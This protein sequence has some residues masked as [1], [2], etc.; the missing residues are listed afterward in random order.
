MEAVTPGHLNAWYDRLATTLQQY[1]IHP[2]NLY[3]FDESG[4]RIGEGRQQKV[5]STRGKYANIS[6]GGP[7]ESLTAIECISA[8]G[9]VMPPWFLV[10]AMVHMENWYRETKLPDDYWVVPTPNGW[11]NDI[12]AFEW[13]QSFEALTKT[14]VAKGEFRILLMDNHKSHLTY[15]FIEF[16]RDNSIIPYC[17]IPHTTHICQ[18]LDDVPFQVLKHYF[19]KNNNT[20]VQWGG[21][22]K[23]KSDFFADIHQIRLL[24]FKSRTIRHGFVE[25]GIYPINSEKGLIKMGWEPELPTDP[26]LQIFDGDDPPPQSSS[27]H[28]S[29]I[30]T[31]EKLRSRI[32]K[33]KT[34][35]PKIE[36][37]SS[38]MWRQLDPILHGGLTLAEAGAQYASDNVKILDYKNRREAKKSK[39]QVNMGGAQSVYDSKRHIKTRDEDERRRI[40]HQARKQYIATATARAALSIQQHEEDEI[41]IRGG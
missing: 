37:F 31:V 24:A 12:T 1:K 3:N 23:L 33:F 5:V 8:D 4:F 17:F 18:P 7:T 21:S 29:P 22:V 9:W 2:K 26:V 40:I 16:C 32:V 14:R 27:V 35:G 20:A 6:T 36:S 34:K 10:K 13:L 28:S 11:I 25:C 41:N 30:K 19:R 15:E 38:K 39:R